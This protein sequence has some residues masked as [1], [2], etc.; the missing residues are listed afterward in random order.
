MVLE[1]LRLWFC[2]HI[3]GYCQ[4][5]RCLISGFHF[6]FTLSKVAPLVKITG[7]LGQATG[8]LQLQLPLRSDQN[9]CW[10]MII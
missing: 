5:L 8:V 6:G 10:L 1:C 3:L 4:P 2:G 9:H 7:L